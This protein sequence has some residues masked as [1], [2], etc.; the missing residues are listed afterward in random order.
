MLLTTDDMVQAVRD[1]IDEDSASDI[2]NTS[3]I[4]A[5]NRA[6][7]AGYNIIARKSPANIVTF[8]DVTLSEAGSFDIPAGIHED[9]VLHV[10]LMITDI[11]R[12][13]NPIDWSEFWEYDSRTTSTNYPSVWAVVGRK[14]YLRPNAAAGT[15]V[16]VWHSKVLLSLVPSQGR[17]TRIG[18]DYFVVDSYVGDLSTS[19]DSLSSYFNVVGFNSGSVKGTYQVYN[20]QD[21]KITFRASPTRTE[22][23]DNSVIGSTAAA[24][25]A[26]RVDDFICEAKGTAVP[27]FPKPLTNYV[28]AYAVVELKSRLGMDVVS[29]RATLGTLEK[30]LELVWANRPSTTKILNKSVTWRR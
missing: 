22:V 25:P 26:I 7:D 10:D 28:I 2:T 13:M 16:R 9:R 1:Q 24:A 17:I 23:L 18:S 12:R 15:E 8:T 21:N 29:D 6:Q 30:Q 19:A 4:A 20:I 27:Y 5:L 14:I 3:I 11:P